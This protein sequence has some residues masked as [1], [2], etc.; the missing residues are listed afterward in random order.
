MEVEYL[1][2]GED[3]STLM[4][5]EN[6]KSYWDDQVQHNFRVDINRSRVDIVDGGKKN[7]L[8][9]Y[10]QSHPLLLILVPVNGVLP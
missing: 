8:C 6:P 3:P 7:L 1:D 2:Y 9:F 5:P 10:H 4:F